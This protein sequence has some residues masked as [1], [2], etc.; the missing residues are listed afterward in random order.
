[1]TGQDVGERLFIYLKLGRTL[2]IMFLFTADWLGMGRVTKCNIFMEEPLANVGVKWCWYQ[3]D[4][5][6]RFGPYQPQETDQTLA[7]CPAPS[8][9][10]E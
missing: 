1:M 5:G 7:I 8:N 6:V 9:W 2:M 4:Q 3:G 10:L